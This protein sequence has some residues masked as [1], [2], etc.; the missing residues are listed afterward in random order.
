VGGSRES[1]ILKITIPLDGFVSVLD[2]AS[3]WMFGAN[4]E[5]RVDGRKRTE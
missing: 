3:S 1:L 4:Q 2:G 5:A